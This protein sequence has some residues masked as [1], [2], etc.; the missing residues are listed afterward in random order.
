[1]SKRSGHLTKGARWV[2]NEP[3]KGGSTSNVSREMGKCK[4]K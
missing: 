3:M 2:T 4:L 1:M